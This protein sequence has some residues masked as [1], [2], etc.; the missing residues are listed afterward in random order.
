ME[1]TQSCNVA[2]TRWRRPYFLLCVATAMLVSACGGSDGSSSASTSSTSSTPPTA[3][4]TLSATPPSISGT[5]AS[6]VVVGAKY[7]F[8]PSASDTD[9]DALTFSIENLPAWATFDTTSGV[10]S[11]TPT[12]ANVG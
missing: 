8:R 5:P 3:S 4:D 11:G 1:F 12:S 10:L 6:S 2:R 7:T 9:G